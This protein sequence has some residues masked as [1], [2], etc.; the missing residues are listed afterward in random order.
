MLRKLLARPRVGAG[1]LVLTHSP[2]ILFSATWL[3]NV[4]RGVDD[5]L[6][7][8]LLVYCAATAL[9]LVGVVVL[10]VRGPV[11]GKWGYR[12][13]MSALLNIVPF[14]VLSY[15]TYTLY[16]SLSTEGFVS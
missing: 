3:P 14:N 16:T 6:G 12:L 9:V 10:L 13:C 1:F 8:G 11:T 4:A 5:A 2:G 7:L 15:I